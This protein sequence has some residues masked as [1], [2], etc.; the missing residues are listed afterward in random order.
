MEG[1]INQFLQHSGYVQTDHNDIN[2]L[3]VYFDQ[4][5]VQFDSIDYVKKRK[6]TNKFLKE[7]KC[8]AHV[9]KSSK[10][11]CV[12]Q[13]GGTCSVVTSQLSP[14]S[15]CHGR[16]RISLAVSIFA[17]GAEPQSSVLLTAAIKYIF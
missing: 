7:V 3:K 9:E 10:L 4:S 11:V 6:E 8:F 13:A 14:I 12:C 5:C 1:N 15:S 16:H 2:L 17:A